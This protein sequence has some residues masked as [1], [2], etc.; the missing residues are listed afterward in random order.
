MSCQQ[1][2]LKKKSRRVG[3]RD[4]QAYR[5]KA[6]HVCEVDPGKTNGA[7]I[8][9]DID[10]WIPPLYRDEEERSKKIA[11]NNEAFRR[12]KLCL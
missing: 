7:Q 3:C 11:R 10:K 4:C 1:R 12:G 5:V 6:I 9:K 8:L 2:E